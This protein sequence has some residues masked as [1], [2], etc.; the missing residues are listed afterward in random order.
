MLDFFTGSQS[1]RCG[2]E[3]Y[4]SWRK[5]R[6]T[7]NC[8]SVAKQ[9]EKECAKHWQSGEEIQNLRNKPRRNEELK[10]SEEAL[11][12]L[13]GGDLEKASRLFKSS[14]GIDRRDERRNRGEMGATSLYDDVFLDTEECYK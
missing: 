9:K 13:K 7:R 3:E 12:R 2:G 1:Q 4:R 11:P 6:K 14:S 8:W 5:S 10:K